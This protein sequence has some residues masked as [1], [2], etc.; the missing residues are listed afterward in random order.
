MKIQTVWDTT[1]YVRDAIAMGQPK[2]LVMI[3]HEKSEEAGMK[4]LRESLWLLKL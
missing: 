2:A 3:G 1:E 4:Y